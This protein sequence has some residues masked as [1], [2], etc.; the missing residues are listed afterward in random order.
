MRERDN[1]LFAIAHSSDIRLIPPKWPRRETIGL[2][3]RWRQE[4]LCR[5]SIEDDLPKVKLCYLLQKPTVLFKHASFGLETTNERSFSF[6]IVSFFFPDGARNPRG[7]S[8]G[9]LLEKLEE[10]L[11]IHCTLITLKW[12]YIKNWGKRT[13]FFATQGKYSCK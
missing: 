11:R 5:Q 4:K 7:F 3:G 13:Y 1:E 10:V 2:S 8:M 6:Q 12:L 9:L